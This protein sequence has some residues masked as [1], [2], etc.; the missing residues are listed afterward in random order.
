MKII[1]IGAEAV[2]SREKN[3]LIKNRIKKSYRIEE[4]DNKIRKFRTKRETKILSKL[5]FVPKV[6][7]TDEKNTTI[8]ME[9]INGDLIRNILDNITNE[10]RKEIC[11]KIGKQINEMH[12]KGIIHGDL[13]TSNMILK[14]NKIFFIDFGLG[15]FSTR[16]EDKATDLRLLR[17]ALESK[18]YKCFD[19]VYKYI[20]EGYQN[21]E[22]LDWLKNKVEKRGRYK[23]KKNEI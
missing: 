20:L 15:F 7:N 8:E 23:R 11:K 21:Q 17:Q 2:L 6:L 3:K 5:D 13:T 16:I 19:K 1:Q 12:Q 22:V 4:I 18:H 10:K 9:F 14:N